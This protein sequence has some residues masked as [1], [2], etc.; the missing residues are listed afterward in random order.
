MREDKCDLVCEKIGS[1]SWTRTSDHSIN[2]S[3]V[4]VAALL[5]RVAEMPLSVCIS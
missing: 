5:L 1:P 3:W 2:R 4:R